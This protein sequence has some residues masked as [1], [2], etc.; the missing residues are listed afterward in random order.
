MLLKVE[1]QILPKQ[2]AML[3]D[4]QALKPSL[5]EVLHINYLLLLCLRPKD[6]AH[7]RASMGFLGCTP[8]RRKE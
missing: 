8:A 7:P 5:N 4:C 6:N 1:C 2:G 3:A